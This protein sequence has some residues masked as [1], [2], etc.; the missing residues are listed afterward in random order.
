ML[1][2]CMD[3]SWGVIMADHRA[4]GRDEGIKISGMNAKPD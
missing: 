3:E 2:F 1:D 4:Y